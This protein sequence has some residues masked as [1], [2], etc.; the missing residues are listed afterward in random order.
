MDAR[1]DTTTGDA[2]RGSDAGRDEAM[3]LPIQITEGDV[4]R[5]LMFAR[6]RRSF[7]LPRYT[8]RQWWEADVF[9]L[10]PSGYFRE[11]E[12]KLTLSDFRADAKK[13]EEWKWGMPRTGVNE[14]K[15]QRL[16]RG[17]PAGPTQFWFVAPVGVIPLDQVP[18]WAGLIEMTLHFDVRPLRMTERQ[19][20][21]PPRLH[22][23]KSGPKV[24]AHAR[25]V[26][27]YRLHTLMS[28]MDGQPPRPSNEGE[29]ATVTAE[30]ALK[31]LLRF[32]PESPETG[33]ELSRECWTPGYREAVEAAEKLVGRTG[34]PEER[35]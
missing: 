24:E 16:A 2:E 6:Y 5:N 29:D 20:K 23:A 8:P 10:T 27:Y 21:R 35:R 30:E 4:A 17:D 32:H 12:I 25:S 31:A 26:I 7:V 33:A 9:E 15:H 13:I 11:Y 3:S 14:T 28:E 22:K 19:A 1:A 18:D 34:E